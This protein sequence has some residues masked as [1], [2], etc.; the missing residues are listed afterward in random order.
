M[1]KVEH[2][3]IFIKE[4]DKLRDY[5][6][7]EAKDSDKIKDII[8]DKIF[9]C[10]RFVTLYLDLLRQFEVRNYDELM[11]VFQ[12]DPLYENFKNKVEDTFKNWD[13]SLNYINKLYVA[14]LAD[15]P[16]FD[17]NLLLDEIEFKTIPDLKPYHLN[18]HQENYKL[19]VLL[20]HFQ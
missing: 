14:S 8:K 17:H 13:A 5:I 10:N 19:I 4:I 1:K 2:F 12:S 16:E 11:N 6:E 18:D 3:E 15:E 9:D 7:N 20:R